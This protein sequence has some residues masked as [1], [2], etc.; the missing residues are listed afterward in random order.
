MSCFK[1]TEQAPTTTADLRT[2]EKTLSLLS[3]LVD[4]KFN[5]FLSFVF[6]PV[7]NFFFFVWSSLRW[8]FDVWSD[9]HCIQFPSTSSKNILSS[10]FSLHF[11]CYSNSMTTNQF[12]LCAFLSICFHLDVIICSSSLMKHYVKLSE[13]TSNSKYIRSLFLLRKPPILSE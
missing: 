13:M 11:I 10:L 6:R 12:S 8:C 7:C 1:D 4:Y 2:K 3:I 5:Q 9:L